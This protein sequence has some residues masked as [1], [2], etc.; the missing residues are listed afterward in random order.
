MLHIEVDPCSSLGFGHW[1]M[2]M[3]MMMMKMMIMLLL[4]LVVVVVAVAVVVGIVKIYLQP[5]HL[6]ELPTVNESMVRKF[7]VESNCILIEEIITLFERQPLEFSTEFSV[8]LSWLIWEGRRKIDLLVEV[9]SAW[10]DWTVFFFS[11]ARS[12]YLFSGFILCT[13]EPKI[14]LWRMN[15]GLRTLDVTIPTKS[16]IP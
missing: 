13:S 3:M 16:D 15:L 2:M 5:W 9:K 6:E 7:A 1:W 14:I 11:L 10:L 8:A 12:N 4:L